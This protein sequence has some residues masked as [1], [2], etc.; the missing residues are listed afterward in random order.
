MPMHDRIAKFAQQAGVDVKELEK[1][2]PGGF[3]RED[4]IVLEDFGKL[5]AEDCAKICEEY[6]M[7]DGTS[8]TALILAKVIRNKYGIKND[9]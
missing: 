2:Y 6:A 3:P 5:I 8:E 9:R 4:T 7:P 1:P